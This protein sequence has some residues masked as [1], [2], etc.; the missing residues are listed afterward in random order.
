MADDGIELSPRDKR[1]LARLIGKYGREF[2]VKVAQ[3]I[4]YPRRGSP[5]WGASKWDDVEWI[6][7]RADELRNE[8]VALGALKKATTERFL[9]ITPQLKQTAENLKRFEKRIK[10]ARDE[11]SKAE[12]LIK[13]AR[14]DARK[15]GRVGKRRSRT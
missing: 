13:A 5:G 9:M 10:N 11:W 1:E 2:V 3:K 4:R 7:A 14:T 12:R 8:G 15:E 6:E